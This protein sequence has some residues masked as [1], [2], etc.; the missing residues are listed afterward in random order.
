MAVRRIVV[1]GCGSIGQRHARLLAERPDLCVEL[2]DTNADALTAA[3]AVTGNPKICR[4]FE[5]MLATQ[6]NMVVV[7]TPHSLHADQTIAALSAGVH[8]LC[9]K[10]MSDSL[11]DA[12]RMA[13]AAANARTVLD[14]GFTM[15]FHPG[16]HRLKEVIASGELGAVL[17]AHCRIGTYITLVCSRSRHQADL[18]GALLF[19]YVHQPDIFHWLMG[20]APAGVY[21][22]A[23]FGGDLPLRSNPN[24]ADMTLDYD[25]P[26]LS[27]IHFN[28]IQMP[29]RHEYEIVGDKAWAILDMETNRLRI[30]R[31][32]QEAET[33]ET[34][35]VERDQLFVAEHQAFLDAVDGRR[36]P[37]SPASSA[38][39]SMRVVDAALRSW[40]SRQRVAIPRALPV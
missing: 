15:H 20:V 30:G 19:D 32:E 24:V 39:V 36:Q 34:I 7:A 17:H 21:M 38:I 1:S 23:V 9:E 3:A 6:P 27:T 35:A 10:P 4:D 13:E 33:C 12:E 22:T 40:K 25:A 37:E 2:C 29:Q 18:E 28:Y 16:L 8:V 26:L 5:E 11:A 14:F 31:R